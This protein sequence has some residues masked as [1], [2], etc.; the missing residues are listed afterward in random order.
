MAE[1]VFVN[2]YWK[3][4]TFNTDQDPFQKNYFFVKNVYL[5]PLKNSSNLHES[6]ELSGLLPKKT[7]ISQNTENFHPCIPGVLE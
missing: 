4:S 5:T 6:K 3:F 1:S 7:E 2:K